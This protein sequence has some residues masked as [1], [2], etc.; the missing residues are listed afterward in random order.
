MHSQAYVKQLEDKVIQLEQENKR[1]HE[2]VEFLTRK[3][4]GRSSEKTSMIFG[5]ANLFDEAETETDP[6]VPEPTLQEIEGYRRKKFKGQR[7]ELLKDLPH[8][9]IIC[10][11]DPLDLNCPQCD[12]ALVE[13]GE[14]F[15]RTEVEYIPAKVRVIDYYRQ[16]YECR[17]CKNTDRP[18]FEKSPMPYPVVMHSM[19]SA[20][21][22]AHVIYQKFVNAL[23]LYR[24]EKDW[25]NL[26]IR[27]GRATM[28]NWI[29][30]AARDWLA[31]IV[32]LLHQK[33]LQE[34]YIHADETKIQVMNEEGRK[35]TT[36]SYMW[37]YGTYKDSKKPIRIFEYQQTRNGRH[38][39]EFLKGFKGYLHTDAYSGYNKVPE[40]TR[41]LCWSHLRR[42]FVDALPKDIKSPEATL[43]GEGIRYCNKLFEIET[44]LELLSPDERKYKRLELELPVLEAFW[45]WVEKNIGECLPKGKLHD[46]MKYAVNQKEG[47]MAY[48]EDG[49]CSISNNLAEN[50]IRP[51]TVGRRNWLFSGSPKGADASAAAYS[52]IETA[53]A[54]GLN[55]YNYLWF[56]FKTMPGVQ[57]EEHPEFLE[58]F[59]PWSEDAIAFCKKAE[60]QVNAPGN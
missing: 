26:G 7:M 53:K 13:V 22:V 33:L 29:M 9:K 45:S 54:N 46:A 35:N 43:P 24:Q 47:L 37:V 32:N 17:S 48:L 4:F 2:S 30:V 8:D 40:I 41:C 49:N 21:S 36:D 10:K 14:E 23:P 19:A 39:Q 58:D 57:F 12:T 25:E 56:I 5:Q 3:L 60:G 11:L 59:L 42:Y 50:S 28:S 38:P 18:Y 31:P 16:S 15:I 55:P 1:L 52:I 51:F 34:K 6:K 20:S 44:E 27:L